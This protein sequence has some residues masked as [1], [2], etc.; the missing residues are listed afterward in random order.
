MYIHFCGGNAFVA[1]HLLNGPQIGAVLQK[2][3]GKRV[4]ECMWTDGF[5]NPAT[6]T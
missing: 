2:V 4:P 5:P 6:L 3:G 1:E